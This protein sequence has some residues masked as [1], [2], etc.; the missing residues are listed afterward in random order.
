MHSFT[1][2]SHTLVASSI[3]AGALATPYVTDPRQNTSYQG[4]ITSPGIESFLGIPYGKDTS[5]V[6][7]F[8]PPEP[9]AVPSG[10]VF[11]ATVEGPSCPQQSGGGFLYSTNVTYMS[12]NCLNL[13]LARPAN[14]TR[15][16]KLPVM[17]YIYGGEYFPRNES[18]MNSQTFRW[19]Q[20][21]NCVR[22]N[23]EPRRT[24]STIC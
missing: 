5:G 8:A 3:I 21:W 20:Y 15:G 16:S 7:R 22:Q 23:S 12:E 18:R 4:I 19:T 14:V 11:N 17:A 13:L 24:C 6:R 1:S 9:F 10:Y 2:F